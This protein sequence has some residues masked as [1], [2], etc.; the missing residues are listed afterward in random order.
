MQGCLQT[1]LVTEDVITNL[2]SVFK[3]LEEKTTCWNVF[4]GQFFMV[5]KKRFVLNAILLKND[6][7]V[8]IYKMQWEVQWNEKQS[9]IK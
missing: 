8:V 6:F 7:P 4:D 2:S 1:S 3:R 9:T 5:K